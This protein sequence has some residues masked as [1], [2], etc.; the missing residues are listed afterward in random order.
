M[1]EIGT[2]VYEG[3]ENFE[4]LQLEMAL[5]CDAQGWCM[6]DGYDE[7]TGVR[8]LI[9]NPPEVIPEEDIFEAAKAEKLNEVDRWTARR[10]VGGFDSEITGFKVRYDSDKDTQL[11]MQG[12]ALNVNSAR[13]A[14]EYPEGCPVRGYRWVEVMDEEGNM[15][16]APSK[17][18]EIF[19]FS[20]EQVLS[21]QADL[22]VHIGTCK[23]YGW[24]YQEQVNAATT[25]EELEAIII[26]GMTNGNN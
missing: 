8:Y 19:M 4:A 5:T 25:L 9:I 26:G 16:T 24:F 15:T 1:M 2:R 23:Q 21:W 13:F 11:T 12:I 20:P 22:S 7:V 10:I 3:C 6:E 18:K 17:T 14:A